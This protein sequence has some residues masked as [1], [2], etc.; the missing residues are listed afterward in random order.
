LIA[1]S[2]KPC[3]GILLALH[4]RLT[5]LNGAETRRNPPRVWKWRAF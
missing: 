4:L 1:N 5:I 3:D 2:G